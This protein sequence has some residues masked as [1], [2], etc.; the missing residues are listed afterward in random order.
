MKSPI[1]QVSRRYCIK[2]VP[3]REGAV[4]HLDTT[5]KRGNQAFLYKTKSPPTRKLKS[6]AVAFDGVTLAES[7][8]A[9]E[10]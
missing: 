1:A 7:K 9:G 6:I 2:I 4:V 10:Y 8:L 3:V 5:R